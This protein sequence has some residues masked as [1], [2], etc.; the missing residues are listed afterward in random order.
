[1]PICDVEIFAL[2]TPPHR[3]T[4]S[5][6]RPPPFFSSGFS[7]SRPLTTSEATP[8]IHVLVQAIKTKFHRLGGL[9]NKYLFITVLSH[10]SW[11]LKVQ[12][13]GADRFMS[14]EGPLSGLQISVFSL[15]GPSWCH[16]GWGE[17]GWWEWMVV[18]RDWSC[19]SLYI[20][21]LISSRG[22]HPHG[23]WVQISATDNQCCV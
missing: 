1:M 19:D 6:T 17:W 22:P 8:W 5:Y 3:P 9:N 4:C 23:S 21:A 14:G 2:W 15:H 12:D 13:Q 7:P 10:S 16:V 20:R 11:G 18:G